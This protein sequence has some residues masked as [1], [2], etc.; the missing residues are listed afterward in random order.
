MRFDLRA[1][2]TLAKQQATMQIDQQAEAARLQF[3]TPGS[4]QAMEYA[5]TEQEALKA[6]DAADPLNPDDYPWLKAEQDAL[7]AAGQT[8]TLRDVVNAVLAQRE[9]WYQAG[10]AIKEIRRGAKM[11]VDAAQTAAEVQDILAGLSWPTP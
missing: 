6:K 11:K 1:D 10:V 4:G 9:A 7:A 2:L 8:A 5:A 3:L